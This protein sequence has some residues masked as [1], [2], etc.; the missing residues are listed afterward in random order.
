MVVWLC[1][2]CSITCEQ[3]PR[4]LPFVDGCVLPRPRRALSS[5]QP[6]ELAS[7]LLHFPHRGGR[8]WE[9]CPCPT[10]R[11]WQK[12]SVSPA[13]LRGLLLHAALPH[14]WF[15]CKEQ[16]DDPRTPV[17]ARVTAGCRGVTRLPG[18]EPCQPTCKSSESNIRA[19]RTGASFTDSL[20]GY[21]GLLERLSW[22]GPTELGGSACW[23][24]TLTGCPAGPDTPRE[25]LTFCGRAFCCVVQVVTKGTRRVH[26]R[27]YP[28]TEAS[29]TQRTD[30]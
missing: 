8:D 25:L 30:P 12:W 10:T 26:R 15:W 28:G 5:Q 29:K 9:C 7:P 6:W 16:R 14:T 21:E 13:G 1:S 22:P 11:Q 18:S 4:Q 24:Q 3:R 2:A 27:P 23:R 20:L 17:E 19:P